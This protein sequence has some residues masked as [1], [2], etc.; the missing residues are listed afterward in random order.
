MSE[1]AHPQRAAG[2][3]AW[4][5]GWAL[6]AW[7]AGVGWFAP[8]CRAQALMR[9][10]VPEAM[11]VV[12]RSGHVQVLMRDPLGFLWL[13]TP[14]GLVRFDGVTYQP[15]ARA[16]I[17]GS[18]TALASGAQGVLWVGMQSGDVFR[19]DVLLSKTE[20]AFKTPSNRAVD[21]LASDGSERLWV[22]A[23]DALFVAGKGEEAPRTWL[24]GVQGK[25]V[26]RLV[27]TRDGALW[28]GTTQ[29]LLRCEWPQQPCQASGPNVEILLFAE[30]ADNRMFA[31]ASEAMFFQSRART[32]L[33]TELVVEGLAP[34]FT[35]ALPFNNGILIADHEGLAWTDGSRLERYR[36]PGL[37]EGAA[38]EAASLAP[39]QDV[40]MYVKN[41]GLVQMKARPDMHL[42]GVPA[43]AFPR[44]TFSLVFDHQGRLWQNAG[45]RL[46]RW[47]HG[48]W[49][50]FVPP[51]VLTGYAMRGLSLD[52]S[53][54][55]WTAALDG[56]VFRFSHGEFARLQK[57]EG[58]PFSVVAAVYHDSQDRT[59]LA[60]E[61]GGLAYRVGDAPFVVVPEASSLCGASVVAMAEDPSGGLWFASAGAGL[62]HHEAGR[63]QAYKQADGLPS[64]ALR[65]L[66]VDDDGNL[67]IGTAHNGLVLR[68]QSRF[69]AI[70]PSAQLGL[71]DVAAIN[72][73]TAGSL[74]ISTNEGLIKVPKADL[75]AHLDGRRDRV[76]RLR[77][78]T[79]DG[80]RNTA[81]M[82]QYPPA[83]LRSP[84]GALYFP[85]HAGVLVVPDPPAVQSPEPPPLF[86]E[87]VRVDGRDLS[88]HKQGIV[89]P[90]ESTLDVA[91][92]APR[93]DRP[94][95]VRFLHRLDG[96]QTDWQRTTDL[97][98]RYEDLPAGSY[99]L[100]LASASDDQDA[101]KEASIAI[102]VREAFY[103]QVWFLAAC[104]VL[105]MGLGWG[106]YRVR[107]WSL[108]SRFQAIAAERTRIAR[109]M[110]D[111]LEQN[112]VAVKLQLESLERYA[113]EPQQVT[114]HTE[115]ALALLK[116]TMREAKGSIWSLRLGMSDDVDLA[117]N[118]S[119]CAGRILKGT[120][121][122]F[123]LHTEGKPY[124][125]PIET[126][127]QLLRLVQ[128]GLTNVIKHAAATNVNLRLEFGP[129]TLT[130]VL[131]DDGVG[132]PPASVPGPAG[133]HFGLQGMRERTAHLGG[134]MHV[135]SEVGKGVQLVF[136]LP[137]SK[138]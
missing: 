48:E 28:I 105:A 122:R 133:G 63:W 65:A 103:R 107:M 73:D 25:R 124:R 69:V 129:E 33:A 47:D 134:Q 106:S 109:D 92:A 138:R 61:G 44:P 34:P 86:I 91:F 125:M 135:R 31:I 32:S 74:W 37:P 41:V 8:P 114:R 27:V 62:C 12:P 4:L 36:F 40:W 42:L 101:Q 97:N 13:G 57:P 71:T 119:V 1:A 80:L 115:T 81:F 123:Q 11:R 45:A 76:R 96:L 102:V 89:L 113:A 23:G 55:L 87:R 6:L 17:A 82:A 110:H 84:D 83:S 132:L 51:S 90:E 30:A 43:N 26:R 50:G 10:P 58:I 130:L 116:Q 118:L 108:R 78:G 5:F 21:S 88:H 35:A 100:R 53:G 75:L 15:V 2:S 93:L 127:Q 18:V 111:T 79:A 72:E 104:A 39:N 112:L 66:H 38:V 131:Q 9:A 121:L 19:H 128:E 77:F 24:Q 59:W 98:V 95:R 22:A 64:D 85:S 46:W 29:G 52:S 56:G 136:C 68:R 20:L 16:V 99:V 94:H 7:I 14:E 49:T 120:P 67:W 137:R 3:S 70:G 60:A 117:T 54:N 126:E